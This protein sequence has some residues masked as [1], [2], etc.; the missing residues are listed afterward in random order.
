MKLEQLEDQHDPLLTY[1]RQTY[2]PANLPKQIEDWLQESLEICERESTRPFQAVQCYL[3]LGKLYLL[4]S[5]YLQAKVQLKRAL[6]RLLDMQKTE[7]L[8]YE[9]IVEVHYDLG[10]V[11]YKLQ[12]YQESVDQYRAAILLLQ[13]RGGDNY[14]SNVIA[15][16][17]GLAYLRA[18]LTE[19]GNTLLQKSKETI[20]AKNGAHHYDYLFLTS[21]E[22]LISKTLPS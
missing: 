22:E 7:K 2:S 18:G 17:L 8:S 5:D 3:N 11:S 12:D 1:D 9:L 21:Q 15:G 16:N 13:D 10:S 14:W 4:G 19:R 20:V 6:I